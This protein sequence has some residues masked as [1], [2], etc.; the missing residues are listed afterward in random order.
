MK[1]FYILSCH[2]L[3]RELSYFAACSENTF[4]FTF[5]R[6]G[7]HNTP[8]HLRREV[9]KEIERIEDEDPSWDAIL[10]GYGL[11]SNGLAGIRS[12][13]TT[14]AAVRAHDCITLLLGS[15]ERYRTYFDAHP[16]TYWYS[17][18]WIETNDQP[19]RERYEKTLKEYREKY[20]EENAAFLMETEQKWMKEYTRGKSQNIKKVAIHGEN[21]IQP[22]RPARAFMAPVIPRSVVWRQS[23]PGGGLWNH[24]R[25]LR[26]PFP[27]SPRDRPIGDERAAF[28]WS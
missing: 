4:N 6:Q 17:P 27:I 7:L 19:G 21:R 20:G 25:R 24:I 22:L 5:L 15:K 14:L 10:L 2:V 18:G 28:G 16:G 8:E 11:C 9:Q 3:W 26:W 1:R 13:K 12:R 23:G